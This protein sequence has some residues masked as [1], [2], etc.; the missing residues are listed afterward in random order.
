MLREAEIPSKS[1]MLCGFQ[2]ATKRSG[3]NQNQ[4]ATHKKRIGMR[5]A[6]AKTWLTT[7]VMRTPGKLMTVVTQMRTMVQ[8]P[9]SK[10]VSVASKS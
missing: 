5:S 7:P 9:I 10:G 4:P 3:E 2:A 1:V 8:R 6:Q